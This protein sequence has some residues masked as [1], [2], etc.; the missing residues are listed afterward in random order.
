MNITMKCFATLADGDS[1]D[2]RDSTQHEISE[3]ETVEHLVQRLNLPR[4]EVHIVFVNG[5]RGGLDTVLHDGDRLGLAPAT[6]GM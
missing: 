6:G 3:G 2:W 5:K 4:E 1:C